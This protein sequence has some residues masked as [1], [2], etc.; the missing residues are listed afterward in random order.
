MHL[1]LT[2]HL[3]CTKHILGKWG[4]KNNNKKNT[5]LVFK[6]YSLAVKADME[7]DPCNIVREI[8]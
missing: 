2:E 4:L 6:E 8:V 7:G 1:R 5:L 3:L